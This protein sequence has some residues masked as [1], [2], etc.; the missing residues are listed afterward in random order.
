[1]RFST[2]NLLSW[3]EWQ[4]HEDVYR[5][6]LAECR[7]ADELS[8]DTVWLA[9][10][11][12]SPY[13]ICP[14]LPVFA[15]AVARETRRV[16]IGT[17]VV[18]EPFS[19]PVRIAEEWAMVDILSGGRVEFGL[20]RGYQPAEFRGLGVSMERTRERFDEGLE[21]IRR[22]WTQ[23]R[24]SF[25]GEFY[26]FEDVRVLPR[27][28]QRPHPPLWTAAVS[29]DT[30]ELAA[31]RGLR[32]LTS[33]A[34]TPLDLLRKNYD[35]YRETFRTTHGSEA[36][37][38]ICLNKIIHVADSSREA[39]DNM[40]EPIRWFFRTQASLI[41]D[42]TGAPPEQYAFYRR[43]RENLLSL[44]EETA[45]DQAAI[46]GDPEEVAD[47]IR[48][49]H[50]ALGVTSFMGAFSRGGLAHDTVVRSMRLFAEKVMP[51]F[52]AR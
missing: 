31:R 39:R 49:H 26:R 4:Q 27:P 2:Q 19:H 29:P 20:G 35:R 21:V 22:A 50:E 44:S 38:D 23:E 51:R 10:H 34:F 17:A 13:G 18:I 46:V 48:A 33:P 45:L 36:G 47:K 16:R 43:V 6:S 14:S 32:I 42:P 25:Q 30:Y 11:H 40:R 41:A 8:F 9:E 12:F 37:A 28:V 24:L 52:A 7:L 3:R 5:E 15:A 1:M